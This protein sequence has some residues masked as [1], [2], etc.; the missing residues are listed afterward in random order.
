MIAAGRTYQW[1]WSTGEWRSVPV[2]SDA[3]GSTPLPNDAYELAP[4]APWNPTEPPEAS[5]STIVSAAAAPAITTRR[6]N[7]ARQRPSRMPRATAYQPRTTSSATTGTPCVAN[8]APKRSAASS[9]SFQPSRSRSARTPRT[10]A[11][12]DT[13]RPTFSAVYTSRLRCELVVQHDQGQERQERRQAAQA[14][15]AAERPQTGG[16]AD[17][18]HPQERAH[19][20]QRR[21]PDDVGEP[22]VVAVQHDLADRRRPGRA[23]LQGVCGHPARVGDLEPVGPVAP[24]PEHLEVEQRRAAQ[25]HDRDRDEDERAE[26]EPGAVIGDVGL[27]RREVR[28]HAAAAQAG[29]VERGGD[30]QETAQER[31]RMQHV[32]DHEHDRRDADHGVAEPEREREPRHR[33]DPA[34]RIDGERRSDP[35]HEHERRRGRDR[36]RIHALAASAAP[37]AA[38]MDVPARK[39]VRSH[40]DG[41]SKNE[42]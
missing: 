22:G 4:D 10:S 5:R 28:A 7:T 15:L 23:P 21:P 20:R 8:P 30:D 40:I 14:E 25:A 31:G 38:A 12:T 26:G 42:S 35:G 24:R 29:H 3:V 1:P 27:E 6:P 16:E 41:S 2:S 19:R 9:G 17:R 39:P 11:H 36:G 32:G 18:R 37:P 33:A 34:R 13:I